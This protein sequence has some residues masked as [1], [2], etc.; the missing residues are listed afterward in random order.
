[1]PSTLFA[2]LNPC[3]KEGA[4]SRFTPSSCTMMFQ[5]ACANALFYHENLCVSTARKLHDLPKHVAA[6]NCLERI[7]RS[8]TNFRGYQPACK[9]L[10]YIL[11]QSRTV[12]SISLSPGGRRKQTEAR[13]CKDLTLP[14]ASS[15]IGMLYDWVLHCSSIV[16][17]SVLSGS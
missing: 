10:G 14:D 5:T 12:G 13:C 16:S 7:R 17:K 11:L 4:F 15:V 2:R 3:D 8:H 9:H 6:R 1:M